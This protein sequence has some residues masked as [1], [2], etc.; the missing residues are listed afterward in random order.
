MTEQ[1]QADIAQWGY[2]DWTQHTIAADASSRRYVRL[3]HSDGRS[4]ILMDARAGQVAEFSQFLM[5]TTLLRDNALAAPRVIHSDPHRQVMMLED[6]GG[7]DLATHL[8]HHPNDEAVCYEAVQ[9]VLTKLHQINGPSLQ[10]LDAQSAAHALAPLAQHYR[11]RPCDISQIQ[12]ALI[13]AFE[14]LKMVP[15]RL[16]LR[17]FH[18]E[19]IIWRPQRSGMQRVGLLDYQDALYAPAGYDLASLTRDAR[20]DV[21]RQATDR[22]TNALATECG[23][24]PDHFAAQVACLAVQRN[25]RILGIFAKLICVEGKQKYTQF[26]T[27][28]W[29]QIQTDLATPQLANLK[30][31]VERVLTDEDATN[32]SGHAA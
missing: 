15:D 22:M 18:A 16:A 14:Q 9:D 21:S 28:V 7:T 10:K 20:R 23:A 29:T 25:L 26:V 1:L 4:V 31:A 3:R 30:Q 2:A 8:A 12:Q 11:N 13:E 27:R 24:E 6:L 19:N 17:D 5:M 32:L